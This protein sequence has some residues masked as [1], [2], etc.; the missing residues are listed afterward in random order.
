ML[1][2]TLFGL[3]ITATLFSVIIIA[4]SRAADLLL[5]SE[6]VLGGLLG[7]GLCVAGLKVVLVVL[8][9]PKY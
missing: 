1:G 7:A 8:K 2:L 5:T 4:D 3:A 6:A 9:I